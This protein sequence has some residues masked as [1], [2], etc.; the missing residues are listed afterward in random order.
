MKRTTF[1]EMHNAFK[2]KQVPDHIVRAVTNEMERRGYEIFLS[3]D[4][5]EV[6]VY[7]PDGTLA[8]SGTRRK[9]A[10]H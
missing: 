5:N 1:L 2:I 3:D 8:M 9:V 7:R 10:V 4:G 6:Y